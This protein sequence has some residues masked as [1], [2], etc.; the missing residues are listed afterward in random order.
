MTCFKTFYFYHS[1]MISY[2]K[3]LLCSVQCSLDGR[4][5][6]DESR[7]RLTVDGG[8]AC[9]C[10]TNRHSELLHLGPG[11]RIPARIIITQNNLPP[12]RLIHGRLITTHNTIHNIHLSAFPLSHNATV[13]LWEPAV[14]TFSPQ[15]LVSRGP[16]LFWIVFLRLVYLP[17]L[18]FYLF[19]FSLQLCDLTN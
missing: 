19:N 10:N 8:T 12:R 11:Q 5:C 13:Q 9:E 14:S 3:V 1:Q 15:V 2:T 16:S 17:I 7:W 6:G 4:Q 18:Y